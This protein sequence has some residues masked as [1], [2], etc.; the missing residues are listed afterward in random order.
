MTTVKALQTIA[1][2]YGVIQRGGTAEVTSS[3]AKNLVKA[4]L[5]EVLH[6]GEESEDEKKEQHETSK[7]E[8]KELKKPT[9][10]ITD[11][12]TQTEEPKKILK[13]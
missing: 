7:A 10:T 12:T 13:K 8:Q 9:V 3:V 1:G 6:E 2:E 11:K 5:A 4:G